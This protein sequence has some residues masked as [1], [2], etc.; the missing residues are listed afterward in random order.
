MT[1][2]AKLTAALA[3][4]LGINSGIANAEEPFLPQTIPVALDPNDP[5]NIVLGEL[6]YRGGVEIEPGEE[7]VGSLSGLDWWDGQLYAVT[8]DGRW[9]VMTPD[10]IQNRLTDVVEI[11]MGTLRD[12]RGKKLRRDEDVMASAIERGADGSW[13]VQFDANKRIWR[14]VDFLEAAAPSDISFRPLL[15]ERDA[16]ET[17]ETDSYVATGA[18][19]ASNGVCYVL[20][21]SGTAQT[22]FGV[23]IH[24]IGSDG[25]S[26]ELAS[27]GS[28]LTVGKF[29]GLAVREENAATYLYIASDNDGGADNLRTLLMKFEVSSRAAATP[30]VGP[31]VYATQ[32]VELVTEL[33]I[34]TISLETERAPITAANF[35]R[36]VD[37]GRFDGIRCYRAMHVAGG[38]QPSG[39]LQC[40]TQNA[41]DRI[42]P[43]I[44]HEPTNETG[45]SHTNGALSMARFEPGTATGDFSI[46]IRDQRGLD[47]VPNSDDPARRPGFAVFGSVVDGMDVVHAIHAKP[48]DPDKGEGFLKGQLF[49]EPVTITDARRADESEAS[50]SGLE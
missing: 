35:L 15:T 8:D 6:T 45:L 47:A 41:P 7:E 34:I 20:L 18:D 37:E 27:W 49:A 33:G 38:E 13:Q 4:S 46:M 11:E 36:Y 32:L 43:P 50:T 16:V 9:L 28:E 39:F 40:G 30:G 10:A 3:V 24:A 12:E 48:R 23:S 19:C 5:A 44:A 21:R 25:K 1:W 2:R 14:Y 22:G 17:L 31:K 29:E 42:L 26:E